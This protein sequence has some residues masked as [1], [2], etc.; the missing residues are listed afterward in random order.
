MSEGDGMKDGREIGILLYDRVTALDAIG[1][2]EVLSRLPGA[3][4]RFVA[5]TRGEIRTDQ[6]SL[7]LV[8]DFRLAE[9]PRPDI[10]VIPGGPGQTAQM[11]NEEVIEWIAHAHQH[12][13]WSTSVCTGS[14]LLAKA[15]VLNGIRA[16]SH[17]LAMEELA[18]LGAIPVNQRY[19]IDG[20]IVT[21]A[22]VSAGV[23]MAL[24]LAACEAGR[25]TAES[26]Q[27]GIEYDP[28]P[29]FE[30]GTPVKAGQ[31]LA[32]ELRRRSRFHLLRREEEG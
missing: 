6:R 27:L 30:A 14:L 12:S 9:V 7:G 32:D 13:R 19:V 29:P 11:E 25:S 1:P 15:G 3:A 18:R 16:T 26:I 28:Q 10:I 5:T 21:A 20:K 17:W 31:A 22:G 8:A 4:I 23:D 2:Y 24:Q